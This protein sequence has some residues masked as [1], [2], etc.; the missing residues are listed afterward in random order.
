[1]NVV[2]LQ[3][4]NG[5]YSS[6]NYI[7][8]GRRLPS[9]CTSAGKAILAFQPDILKEVLKNIKPYTNHTIL[10][11][12]S[13]STE[14]EKIKKQKYVISDREYDSNVISIGVPV[15]NDVG[16]AIASIT[17]TTIPERLKSAKI[18]NEYITLL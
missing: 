11:S 13:L 2:I 15:F 8:P 4:I 18:R 6:V 1:I 5:E 16:H 9:Y 14:L 10:D 7:H 3:S 12:K 17:I